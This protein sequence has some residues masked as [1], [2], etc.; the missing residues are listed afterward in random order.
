M[1]ARIIDINDVRLKTSAI[2][3]STNQETKMSSE[4]TKEQWL[5][6]CGG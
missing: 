1:T 4:M 6:I 5:A 2:S 3:H